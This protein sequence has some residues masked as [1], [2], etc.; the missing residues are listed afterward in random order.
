MSD[1]HTSLSRRRFA[2][3]GVDLHIASPD[4]ADQT[5]LV[6]TFALSAG[7]A[8][9]T[10]NIQATCMELMGFDPWGMSQSM[11]AGDSFGHIT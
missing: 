6:A 11:M 3:V 2:A 8:T 5:W 10:A 9:R 1:H 7:L 4:P